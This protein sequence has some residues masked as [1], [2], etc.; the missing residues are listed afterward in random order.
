VHGDSYE[1]DIAT[2]TKTL[3]KLEGK[4]LGSFKEDS[5]INTP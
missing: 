5:N 1:R 4:N 2:L 3:H